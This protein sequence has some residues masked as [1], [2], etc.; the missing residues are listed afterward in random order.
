MKLLL[1]LIV[2]SLLL[3]L[4]FGYYKDYHSNLFEYRVVRVGYTK[5]YQLFD[6]LFN[7]FHDDEEDQVDDILAWKYENETTDDDDVDNLEK[8][9]YTWN[10]LSDLIGDNFHRVINAS[11]EI[12]EHPKI[13]NEKLTN[14]IK[15]IALFI[16]N[17]DTRLTAAIDR[18]PPYMF[19]S[20]QILESIKTAINGMKEN[21]QTIVPKAIEKIDADHTE[22]SK[23]IIVRFAK[24]LRQFE[25]VV[26]SQ[27][28]A[29]L[30][31]TCDVA[32]RLDEI[33]RSTLKQNGKCVNDTSE[34]FEYHIQD[35]QGPLMHFAELTLF[36]V[37]RAMKKSKSSIDNFYQLPMQV[38]ILDN[39]FF[40]LFFL[41]LI[42]TDQFL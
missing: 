39:F 42:K 15:N 40:R 8:T 11:K 34:Q 41:S 22:S 14:P 28:D 19:S 20:K 3:I 31:C 29:H 1:I 36:T 12:R 33:I 16:Q 23:T 27:N 7:E 25:N 30:E 38:R 9:C 18:L 35:T 2:G 4:S 13:M 26:Q 21:F 5:F 10:S 32:K 17:Y 6:S 24:I 37:A